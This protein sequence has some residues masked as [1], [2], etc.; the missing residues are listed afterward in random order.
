MNVTSPD[1]TIK[2]ILVQ[3]QGEKLAFVDYING[4]VKVK[5]EFAA[6]TNSEKEEEILKVLKKEFFPEPFNADKIEEISGQVENSLEKVNVSLTKIEEATKNIDR[7][8]KVIMKSNISDD[9]Y[10]EMIKM[11]DEWTTGVAYEVGE[12]IRWD[13]RAW[14]VIQAHTSQS[15]W[16]PQNTPSLFKVITPKK[17]I[18][19]QTGEEVEI[20][21]DFKQPTGGHDAY[22]KGDKILFEGE[23]YQSK[24]DGNTYS[25]SAYAQN[26]ELVS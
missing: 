18:D 8:S 16:Q 10:A 4:T 25:P 23:V 20:I 21:P 14:E 24:V 2:E 15:D 19:P 12:V 1:G 13:K 17:A 3:F 11:Y 26:W 7:I 22:K 6:M 9:D 5:P